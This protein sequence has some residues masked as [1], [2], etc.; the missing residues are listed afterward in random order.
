LLNSQEQNGSIVIVSNLLPFS[1]IYI[2]D[3]ERQGQQQKNT[4]YRD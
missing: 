3:V 4:T 2:N 1:Q